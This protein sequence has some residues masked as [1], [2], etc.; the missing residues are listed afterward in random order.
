MVSTKELLQGNYI[1][2]FWSKVKK[3]D[4]CWNWTSSVSR[5]GYGK[6]SVSRSKWVEAHRISYLIK[7]GSIPDGLCVLHKC[8]NKMCVRPDHLFL[9]TYND[10]VQDCIVKGRARRGKLIPMLGEDHVN[11]KLTNKGVRLMRKM[12]K[13]GVLLKEI[14]NE[15]GCCEAQVSLIV[16]RKAWKHV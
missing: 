5:G 8:D 11:S 7:H 3:G 15:F 1:E 9:G 16:R 4:F 6:F 12:R 10:N 13:A 2:R 14:A